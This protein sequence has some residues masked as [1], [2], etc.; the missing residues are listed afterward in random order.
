MRLVLECPRKI[1]DTLF[2]LSRDPELTVLD[3]LADNADADAEEEIAG[4]HVQHDDGLGD[5]MCRLV[6]DQRERGRDIDRV[7]EAGPEGNPG[8]RIGIVNRLQ[9]LN[10]KEDFIEQ[11]EQPDR[12]QY[13]RGPSRNTD[14]VF[15]CRFPG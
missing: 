1:P 13:P 6:L 14:A 9:P 15:T 8:R 3:E 7:I 2:P 4:D 10:A 12:S 11:A 5:W